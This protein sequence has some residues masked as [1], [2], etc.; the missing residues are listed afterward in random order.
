MN[1]WLVSLHILAA[2]VWMGAAILT[3]AVIASRSR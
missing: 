2:I 1:D 3:T